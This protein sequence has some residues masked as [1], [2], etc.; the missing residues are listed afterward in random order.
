MDNLFDME[1]L[2]RVFR[3]IK[4]DS[5]PGLDGVDYLMLKNL[6]LSGK[7]ILLEYRI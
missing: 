4:R 7:R 6:P 5:A 2:N 1:E 3:M